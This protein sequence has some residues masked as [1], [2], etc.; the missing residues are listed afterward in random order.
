MSTGPTQAE[1]PTGHSRADRRL[2]A[3]ELWRSPR[4]EFPEELR[5]RKSPGCADSDSWLKRMTVL[6]PDARDVRGVH[7]HGASDR[8]G[9]SPA[10]R[11]IVVAGKLV[12][13]RPIRT[14]NE[15]R[16]LLCSRLRKVDPSVRP[17][18]EADSLHR[19]RRGYEIA[20]FQ[21]DGAAI[22]G[23]PEDFVD[24]REVVS[25]VDHAV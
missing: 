2:R 3:A 10:D 19:Q 16:K 14:I 12:V 11:K 1:S 22:V 20:G 9:D 21:G 15:V 23:N 17:G 8:D 4:P 24:E 25:Q 18:V 5:G 13:M 6:T 7:V